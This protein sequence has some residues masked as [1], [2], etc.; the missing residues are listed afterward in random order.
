MVASGR[1][2]L[3]RLGRGRG[4]GCGGLLQKLLFLDELKRG[5]GLDLSKGK[6]HEKDE[7][8]SGER[9]VDE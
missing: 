7:E 5:W 2:G 9:V 1:G 6:G 4:R 8:K 3:G